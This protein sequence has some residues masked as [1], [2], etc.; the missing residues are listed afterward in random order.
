MDE[1]KRLAR[2]E[3][4]VARD[5]RAAVKCLPQTT[6]V[7]VCFTADETI[8]LTLTSPVGQ[9]TLV[10]TL[11]SED[12]E[13]CFKSTTSELTI[14]VPLSDDWAR[15]IAEDETELPNPDKPNS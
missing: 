11:G 10:H 5:F 3:E 12:A 1:R 9:L 8:E 2:Y 7:A 6:R 13:L 4:I 14:T 15:L